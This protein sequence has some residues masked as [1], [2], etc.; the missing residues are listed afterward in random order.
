[1][2]KT[3]VKGHKNVHLALT[4]ST[5]LALL[6]DPWQHLHLHLP[7]QNPVIQQINMKA[8]TNVTNSLLLKKYSEAGGT[9]LKTKPR[10]DP[11]WAFEN[12]PPHSAIN[13]LPTESS[14]NLKGQN[15]PSAS[16]RSHNLHTVIHHPAQLCVH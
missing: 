15:G 6:I 5:L 9:S 4:Y 12:Q 7:L 10:A 16:T 8:R 13:N 3:P 2:A 11:N 1:M 14:K